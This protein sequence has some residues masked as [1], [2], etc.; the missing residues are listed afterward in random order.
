M[1]SSGEPS[2][3]REG[4][5]GRQRDARHHASRTCSSAL[6]DFTY[7]TQMQKP[8]KVSVWQC[9]C[10]NPQAFGSG[11]VP[12]ALVWVLY[13]RVAKPLGGLRPICRGRSSPLSFVFKGYSDELCSGGESAAVPLGLSFTGRQMKRPER[14]SV[15][16]VS[17]ASL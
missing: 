13:V 9:R 6:L 15:P 11:P 4:G 8:L 17:S 16:P 2:L 1:V 14:G 5:C 3:G 7:K 12:E 10:L